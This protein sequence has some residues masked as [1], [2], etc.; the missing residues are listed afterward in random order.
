[1][2]IRVAVELPEASKSRNVNRFI[3][4]ALGVRALKLALAAEVALMGAAQQRM[5]GGQLAEAE[6]RIKGTTE[7]TP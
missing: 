2:N 7:E 4:H 3:R 1:M 6:R 5:T